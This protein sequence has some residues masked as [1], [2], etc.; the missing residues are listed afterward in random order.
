MIPQSLQHGR[1]FPIMRMR[2]RTGRG[3]EG[4]VT[5]DAT[6]SGGPVF[7]EPFPATRWRVRQ[8]FVAG[9]VAREGISTKSHEVELRV[10]VGDVVEQVRSGWLELHT[11]I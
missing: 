6:E 5:P 7:F 8:E 1:E 9:G 10:A 11:R 4:W 2:V 3:V